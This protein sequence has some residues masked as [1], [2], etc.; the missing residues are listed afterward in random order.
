MLAEQ[1]LYD[2]LQILNS[3]EMYPDIAGAGFLMSPILS[4]ASSIV[5]Y[6]GI[7]ALVFVLLRIGA[8]VVLMAGLGNIIGSGGEKG[9]GKV[10]KGFFSFSSFSG[11]ALPDDA[12][13]YIKDYSWKHL[14]MI[15]F[16]G[17]MISGQLFP[18]AGT[19]TATSGAVIA[20]VAN[21]N[22]VPY[23]EALDV[24][25]ESI[26]KAFTKS[27]V[28]GLMEGHTKYTSYMTA[29]QQRLNS[30][31]E[32]T[33]EEYDKVAAAYANAYHS[34]EKYADRIKEQLI[35]IQNRVTAADST[36]NL[37]D[38]EKDLRGYDYNSHKKN[39]D[40][41]LLENGEKSDYFNFNT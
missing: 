33:T 12:A 9:F 34:A 3:P 1:G 4:L 29:A 41:M 30:A 14:V 36:E 28:K 32:I 27:N 10:K 35:T 20:K 16:I 18:L 25:P 39:I 40:H 26:T 2:F 6:L 21:I 15:A 5:A 23:V 11:G 7:V 13:S 31:D 17:L 37:T 24:S 19:L 8:D 22:P 38:A